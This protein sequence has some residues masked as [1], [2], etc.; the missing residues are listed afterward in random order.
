MDVGD[1][2]AGICMS[3]IVCY[4]NNRENRWMLAIVVWADA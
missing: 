2:C 1:R 4:K 3:H